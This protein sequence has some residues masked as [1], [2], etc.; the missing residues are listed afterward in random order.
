[1][2]TQYKKPDSHYLFTERP[3]EQVFGEQK[4]DT[5]R[6]RQEKSWEGGRRKKGR[7]RKS[8]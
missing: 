4:K 2:I 1:M 8:E 5:T 3:E 6:Q 7:F